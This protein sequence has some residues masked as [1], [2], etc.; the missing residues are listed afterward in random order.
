MKKSYLYF[1]VPLVLTALFG[2]VYHRYASVYEQRLA[3]ID[4]Q[5]K[6]ERR[7]K[8]EEEAKQ[9]EKAIADAVAQTEKRKKE[10]ADR[11]AKEAHERDLREQAAQERNKAFQDARKYADKVKGLEK[12]VKENQDEIAK[13]QQD[14]KNLLD[15]QAFL[16]NYV[17][18]AEANAKSL[19]TVLEKIDA[20]DKARAEAARAQKKSS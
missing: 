8:L 14:R 6:E 1:I 15:E 18:Q 11:E 17:K 7:K 20:A 10:K 12:E 19:S 13:I 5:K 16:Q 4:E 2:V 3:Q 9:R